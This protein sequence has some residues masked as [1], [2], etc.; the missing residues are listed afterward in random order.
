MNK[1]QKLISKINHDIAEQWFIEQGLMPSKEDRICKWVL[2]HIDPSWKYNDIERYIQWNTED[3]QPMTNREHV[4]FHKKGKPGKKG[5]E[6]WNKGKH[7]TLS[8]EAKHNISNSKKGEKNP[9]Y[10]KPGTMLGKKMSEE[11]KKKMSESKKD[12]VPWNKGKH[13]KL[14][15]GKRVYYD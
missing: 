15:D 10:G 12:Y 3:L 13:Y 11:S 5:N 4:S 2:H 9:R 8:D 6:P 14:V 1:E 7:Y